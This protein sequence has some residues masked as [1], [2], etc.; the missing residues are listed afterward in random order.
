MNITLRKFATSDIPTYYSWRNDLEV[1]QFDQPG[2]LR[3]MGY[4]EVEAWSQRMVE[5]LTFVVCADDKAIGTC[6]F[7]N[8]DNRNRNAELALVIGDK[9]YWS[10]G[11]GTIVMEKLLEMGFYGLNYHKLYL[12]VFDFNQRAIGLYEK[13]GFTLEGV[14]REVHFRNGK[15][16]DVRYYGYLRH[17]WESKREHAE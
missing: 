1:A 7:M 4:E 10:K 6:A 3:P 9:S 15:Y 16:E 8:C 2:F 5:G 14:E 17:E 11:V 13:M 12:H